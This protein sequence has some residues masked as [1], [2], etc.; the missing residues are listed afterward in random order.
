MHDLMSKNI[1][2]VFKFPSYRARPPLDLIPRRYYVVTY[3]ILR[4]VGAG[5]SEL[6]SLSSSYLIRSPRFPFRR[7]V[8]DTPYRFYSAKM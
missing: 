7:V 3:L 8:V 1:V 4:V 6:G 5:K 2:L